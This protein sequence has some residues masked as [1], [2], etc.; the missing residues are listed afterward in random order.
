MIPIA[1]AFG[2]IFGQ[3]SD[4]Q[5]FQIFILPLTFLMIFPQMVNLKMMTILQKP[6]M[7]LKFFSLFI[8]FIFIP[9]L[10]FLLSKFF[11]Q[12]LRLMHWVLC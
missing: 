9:F 6:N 12:I 10:A 4:T 11:F 1:I 8:N 7:K 5:F 3:L 2:I